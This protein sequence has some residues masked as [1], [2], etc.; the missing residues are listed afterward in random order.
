MLAVSSVLMPVVGARRGADLE[1]ESTRRAAA[2][3]RLRE[4]AVTDDL[5]GPLNRRAFTEALDVALAGPA[6]RG[7]RWP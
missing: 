4:Q 1:A 2:E 5:T 6:E 7:C 3:A